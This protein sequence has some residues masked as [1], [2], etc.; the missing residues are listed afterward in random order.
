[1]SKRIWQLLIQDI[2]ESGNKILLYTDKMSF[3]DF[4][5]DTKT[6]EAV[7]KNFEINLLRYLHEWY[8]HSLPI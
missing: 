5:N 1:M 8:P 4:V 2:I 6:V 7:I 3:D